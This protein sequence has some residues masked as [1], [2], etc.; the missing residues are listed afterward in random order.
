MKMDL[1]HVHR[2]PA[3]PYIYVELK[4]IVEDVGTVSV[5]IFIQHCHSMEEMSDPSASKST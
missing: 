4:D 2:N 3:L 5:M 1:A